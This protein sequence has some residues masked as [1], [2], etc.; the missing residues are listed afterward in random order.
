M[1]VAECGIRENLAKYYDQKS[2]PARMER[3]GGEAGQ[4]PT[5]LTKSRRGWIEADGPSVSAGREIGSTD[6][7]HS[8]ASKL[9]SFMPRPQTGNCQKELTAS[10]GASDFAISG[11]A[12]LCP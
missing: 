3:V 12:Y 1:A 11:G 2:A 5:L 9:S 7:L 8:R 6:F 4:T 10:S